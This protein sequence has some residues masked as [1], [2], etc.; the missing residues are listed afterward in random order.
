[1]ECVDTTTQKKGG[2]DVGDVDGTVVC[3]KS[4]VGASREHLPL[5][6]V[7]ALPQRNAALGELEELS[8]A[9]T[10]ASPEGSRGSVASPTIRPY[11]GCHPDSSVGATPLRHVET[12]NPS[13]LR[14]RGPAG[15]GAGMRGAESHTPD[16]VRERPRSWLPISSP[17]LQ[18]NVSVINVASPS[19]LA[20]A[21]KRVSPLSGQG[22]GSSYGCSDGG[23]TPES[24]Q[25]HRLTLFCDTDEEEDDRGT[26]ASH[27]STKPLEEV[28][29]EAEQSHCRPPVESLV[30]LVGGPP[31]VC[32]RSSGS[33]SAP[34]ATLLRCNN[35]LSARLSQVQV[36]KSFC[37]RGGDWKSALHASHALLADYQRSILTAFMTACKAA[38]LPSSAACRCTHLGTRARTGPPVAEPAP[39]TGTTVSDVHLLFQ[40]YRTSPSASAVDG[41]VETFFAIQ[42][43]RYANWVHH[44]QFEHLYVRLVALRAVAMMEVHERRLTC[45]RRDLGM[46]DAIE[47]FMLLAP[48]PRAPMGSTG[49]R[50]FSSFRIALHALTGRGGGGSGARA[51]SGKR[52]E[53]C[54]ARP[55]HK[56]SSS[57]AP[58]SAMVCQLTAEEEQRRDPTP[59]A[60]PLFATEICDA[61]DPTTPLLAVIGAASLGG[62]ATCDTS[63]VASHA[64]R[65]RETGNAEALHPAREAADVASLPRKR[66]AS[67]RQL[68]GPKGHGGD[69]SSP[70]SS[71]L[72]L[73][74]LKWGMWHAIP[75]A[76]KTTAEATTVD[77]GSD[78]SA[79][80]Q[81]SEGG[82]SGRNAHTSLSQ[83]HREYITRRSGN[84]AL[85]N[86]RMQAKEVVQPKKRKRT[87]PRPPTDADFVNLHSAEVTDRFVK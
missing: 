24:C 56:P 22:T 20:D 52:C 33:A 42:L 5:P 67:H 14:V 36:D 71:G 39:W 77:D 29:Q 72:W 84:V 7:P 63:A 25:A 13:A 34:G 31:G 85:P 17:S 27:N 48:R 35:I 51:A 45:M 15:G 62:H 40:L 78:L 57:V 38:W 49:R 16:A 80:Q 19:G 37:S 8:M 18:E 11:P 21:P 9:A 64:A 41:L 82:L 75:G 6:T 60:E 47:M 69:V 12:A 86:G 74:K 23:S 87:P 65:G 76:H 79:I 61:A 10:A 3:E 58:L 28:A 73:P 54:S 53:R 50:V 81:R 30:A 83:Q 70:S 66:V 43:T 4:V 55:K 32:L 59:R 68:G 44:L 2:E 46:R 26:C 1:M